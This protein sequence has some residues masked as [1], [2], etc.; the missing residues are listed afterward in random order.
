MACS[1]RGASLRCRIYLRALHLPRHRRLGGLD[2]LERRGR[3]GGL[4]VLAQLRTKGLLLE[5]LVAHLG[6]LGLGLGLGL[7]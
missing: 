4:H 5:P 7:G 2:V 3:V 1:L 6:W